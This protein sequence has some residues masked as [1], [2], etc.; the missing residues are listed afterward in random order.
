MLAIARSSVQTYIWSCK[1]DYASLKDSVVKEC[2]I[3]ENDNGTS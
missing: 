1:L 3:T 2:T